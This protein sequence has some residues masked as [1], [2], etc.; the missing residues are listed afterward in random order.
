[1]VVVGCNVFYNVGPRPDGSLPPQFKA[2]MRKVGD[3]LDRNGEAIFGTTETICDTTTFGLMTC[4]ARTVYLHVLHWAGGSCRLSGESPIVETARHSSASLNAPIPRVPPTGGEL[5][6]AG[7]RN[8]VRGVWLLAT[9][10]KL[11]F[12]QEGP[13]L[14]ISGL[15][16][17]APDA[18]NTVIAVD[19]VGKPASHPWS[20]E[21][22]W[23]GSEE[24][25]QAYSQRVAARLGS[26]SRT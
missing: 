21:R 24:R 16:A 17:R 20:R 25:T 2:L 19:V 11:R 18:R 5:H 8:K 10:R 4:G 7:L 13:H 9:G 1:V 3:W 12:R 23:T 14:Y 22:I 6:L 26:W 15:P